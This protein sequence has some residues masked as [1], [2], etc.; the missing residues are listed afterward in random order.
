MQAT[1]CRSHG[2]CRERL[3]HR[4][5]R[6]NFFFLQ[7]YYFL[8]YANISLIVIMICNYAFPTNRP[9]RRCLNLVFIHQ[10][11][12]WHTLDHT[13]LNYCAMCQHILQMIGFICQ[14]ELI[15]FLSASI[16]KYTGF[17]EILIDEKIFLAVSHW[18][19]LCPQILFFVEI[20]GDDRTRH[21]RP[22][23]SP[24]QSTRRGIH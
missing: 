17:G 16:V 9:I 4:R 1:G 12:N 7:I 8:F 2:P 19:Q 22:R 11:T 5:G 13:T 21:Y 10:S 18:I 14:R 24:L 3:S 20:Q 23:R 6:Y 15:I